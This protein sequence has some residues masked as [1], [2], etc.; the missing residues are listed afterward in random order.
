MDPI[1]I[2]GRFYKKD[3]EAYNILVAHSSL[4]A[5]KAV[6]LAKKVSHLKPDIQF[7]KEAA[8]LHDIGIFLTSAKKIFCFGDKPYICHGYLGRELLEKEGLSR[9]ALVCERHVGVG[10]SEKEIVKKK[11]PLPNRDMIPETIEEKII[12]VA[13]KFFSKKDLLHEKSLE[14]IKKSLSELDPKL[15]KKFEKLYKPFENS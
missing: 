10:F 1:K 9:H 12:C 8:M 4:V 5:M 2:I 14:E 6:E 13:D 11:F 15:V 7:V 3:S